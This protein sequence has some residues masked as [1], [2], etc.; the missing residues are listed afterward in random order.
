MPS[1]SKNKIDN[2][3]SPKSQQQQQRNDKTGKANQYGVQESFKRNTEEQ[4]LFFGRLYE[5]ERIIS[6]IYSHKLVLVYAQSGVG[7]TS[8][9]NAS[10]ISTLE[11]RG[12]E[13]LPV[14]RVG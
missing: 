9:F 10:I 13:V 4:N 7:K 11:Q 1:S 14:A 5:T 12:L 2:D 3:D 6:L 8:I